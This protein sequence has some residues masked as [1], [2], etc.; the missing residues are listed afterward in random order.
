MIRIT[1]QE[2]NYFS[3]SLL[4]EQGTILFESVAFPERNILYDAFYTM[5]ASEEKSVRFERKTDHQGN[6]VFLVKDASGN[7]LGKS[8]LYNSEAGMENGIKNLKNRIRHIEITQ[9]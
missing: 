8:Q 1:K 5:K 9:N 7:P 6:F 3:F 4:S 2:S